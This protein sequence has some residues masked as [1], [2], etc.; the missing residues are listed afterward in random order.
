MGHLLNNRKRSVMTP[1]AAIRAFRNNFGF[2]LADIEGVTGIKESVLNEIENDF[3]PL[4]LDDIVRLAAVYEV[5]PSLFLFPNG[6]TAALKDPALVQI[7]QKC[8]RLREER[9]GSSNRRYDF[10]FD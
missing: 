7:H 9:S 10:D 6:G 4:E 2:T 1:G 8:M 5:D 3:G